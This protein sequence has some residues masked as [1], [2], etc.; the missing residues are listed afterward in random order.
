MSKKDLEPS[1][2]YREVDGLNL[3]VDESAREDGVV[4]GFSDRSGGVSSG[5]FA[6]LNLSTRAGDDAGSVEE[7]RARL[8]RAAGLATDSL[9]FLKQVHG[10]AVVDASEAHADCEADAVIVTESGT[11]GGVLTADCVPVVVLGED[12]LAVIHAGWR[13]LVAGA[14]EAGAARVGRPRA[15]WVGPSIKACC[16]EVGPDVV[17]AFQEKA[18]PVED[19]WHVDPGFAAHVVL[20]RIGVERIAASNICTSSDPRYFSYRRDGV[21]GRQAGFAAFI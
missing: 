4:V 6:S 17:S 9:V 18:L 5:A 10:A 1:L 20:R 13:G 19:S 8:M 2:S 15:A 7:N 12:G 11:T 21:T 3:L 14:I 16:Y